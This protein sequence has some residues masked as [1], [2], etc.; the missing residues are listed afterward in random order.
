[1]ISMLPIAFRSI[2]PPA[3]S[4]ASTSSRERQLIQI[5]FANIWFLLNA[6]RAIETGWVVQL[7]GDA[8]FGFCHAN[9]D[10]IS[11][12]FCSLAGSNNPVCFS[13]IPH[14]SEGEKLY[15]KTYYDNAECSYGSPQG[16]NPK[17]M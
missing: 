16:G 1:M 10:M 5:N 4:L 6:V 8:T 14:Q 9:I 3:L 7:N 15:T 12:V 17:G 11:L 2:H 13:Y